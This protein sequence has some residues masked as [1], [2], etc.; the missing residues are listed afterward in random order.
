[1]IFSFW[2][3]VVVSLAAKHCTENDCTQENNSRKTNGGLV[4]HM[5]GKRVN[6]ALAE[7]IALS[8]AVGM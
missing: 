6:Q 4:P 1:V 2:F 7:F 3:S 8:A 5:D